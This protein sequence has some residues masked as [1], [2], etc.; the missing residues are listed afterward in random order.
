MPFQVLVF[1]PLSRA[2]PPVLT[3]R[4]DSTEHDSPFTP[5]PRGWAGSN[6]GWI[7]EMALEG[8][9]FSPRNRLGKNNYFRN[10]PGGPGMKNLPSTVGDAALIPGQGT[11][12]PRATGQLSRCAVTQSPPALEPACHDQREK[13]VQPKN[14]YIF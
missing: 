9:G 1:M 3:L 11:K 4:T 8:L 5:Q 2:T 6:T 13:P 12:I 7:D 14:K 10:F